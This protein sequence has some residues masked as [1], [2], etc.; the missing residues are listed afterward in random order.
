[1]YEIIY[2]Y[3]K[4]NTVLLSKFYKS[5][6]KF[7]VYEIIYDY[8]KHSTVLLSTLSILKSTPMHTTEKI[9]S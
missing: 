6:L 7:D 3:I 5:T 1:M 9:I 2:D 4:P 8:M